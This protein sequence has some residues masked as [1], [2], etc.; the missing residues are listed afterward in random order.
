MSRCADIKVT[1]TSLKLDA[2][3]SGKLVA[4]ATNAF[5][6]PFK[7]DVAVKVE[8]ETQSS[9][10]STNVSRFEFGTDQTKSIEITFQAPADAAP[11][12]YP[13]HIQITNRNPD[14]TTEEDYDNSETLVVEVPAPVK[15]QSWWDQ[16]R[17]MVLIIAAG[18]VIIGGSVTAYLALHNSGP[19]LG[20]ACRD[21][22]CGK[23]QC[24]KAGGNICRAA[25]GEACSKDGD[26]LAA[27]CLKNVCA[28]PPPGAPCDVSKKNCPANQTCK[29]VQGVG[30]T[31]L[32]NG[33]EAC[34]NAIDCGS[35]WCVPATKVCSKA[36]NSCASNDDC[37]PPSTC[38]PNKQ[39][40]LAN[41]QQ[42]Q[43]D[44]QCQAA[45]CI[46]GKCTE[47]VC[48]PPCQGLFMACIHNACQPRLFNIGVVAQPSLEERSALKATR[49]AR[50][51][52]NQ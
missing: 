13:F 29:T 15:Q 23:G 36:D 38:S 32:L 26:C 50:P 10:I 20:E 7:A 8:G 18:A 21:G 52:V 39:C 1:P 33:G 41:G 42:C 51:S 19:E 16:N 27:S 43:V 49:L 35:F 30:D 9:W 46:Q 45:N 44:G 2:T 34:Q 17:W 25:L 11:G 14:A 37:R 48:Q 40:L 6:A 22:T 24:D 12:K 31:C 5:H 4:T 3:R 28:L 47:L